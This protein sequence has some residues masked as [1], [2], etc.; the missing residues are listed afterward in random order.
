MLSEQLLL[1]TLYTNRC[2]SLL[3]RKPLYRDDSVLAAE[4]MGAVEEEG[5]EMEGVH[6]G[7]RV[8]D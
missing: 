5:I 1:Q 2:P 7:K 8:E 4:S 3:P 6:G